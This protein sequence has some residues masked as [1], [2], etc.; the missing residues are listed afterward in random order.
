MIYNTNFMRKE[1]RS[2]YM[3]QQFSRKRQ[4]SLGVFLGLLSFA[5][6]FS[7]QTLQ[8]SVLSDV[9]PQLMMASY[10]STLYIYLT[11]A[12][13]FNVVFY[14]MH[15]EYMT[16]I[17]VIRNRWYTLVQMGYH[18]T[19]LVMAK[20]AARILSQAFIYTVG[21]IATIFL[22]SFLKFPLVLN[23]LLSM[24]IM[25]LIDIVL[26]ASVSLAASLFMK[27]VLNARYVV[28]LLAV[29][30]VIFKA[31]TRYY[32]I[33]ADRTLMGDLSNMF[34]TTQSIFMASSA[35]LILACV[36][37]CLVRGNQLARVYNPPLLKYLPALV[38][39]APGTLVLSSA[40]TKKKKQ[41]MEASADL[42]LVKKKWNLPSILTS[43]AIIAAIVAML[44]TNVLVLAFGYASPER[45]TSIYGTIP[46]V[47]QSSTMEP[48]IM[49]NDVAFFQKVDK[50]SELAPGEILLFKDDAGTVCVA[51]LLEYVTDE[52][53]GE[54][55]GS[56]QVDI[57]NYVDERY[58]GMAAQTIHR[59][60]VYGVHT[61]NNRWFGAVILFANTILGRLILLLIP[62]FLIFF[63]EPMM[64]FFRSI[65]QE[66]S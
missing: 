53:T 10:F 15:Y 45:E 14:I 8:Q 12:L 59:E 37:V 24:Y 61:G 58:R 17:E 13:V 2:S 1:F 21:Y 65:S 39:K 36:A 7:L 23:Y 40:D 62:T 43:I 38:K 18:P 31:A 6:Y 29:G 63:Y 42:M 44:G 34:D 25:G 27:D 48:A 19:R 26:V 49:L 4:I 20:L 50:T 30:L 22:S 11:V 32:S 66:K 52:A 47:F 3:Q 60:Q 64:R 57:L 56:L 5:L 9:V 28:A 41:S 54:K 51:S 33:L 16:F 35:V 46:Y 55:N